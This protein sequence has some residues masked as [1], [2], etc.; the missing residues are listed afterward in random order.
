MYCRKCGNQLPEESFF[1]P[2]CGEKVAP[3][4]PETET[5]AAVAAEPVKMPETVSSAPQ[6]A[7]EAP[8]YTP[9]QAQGFTPYQAPG[10]TP[11]RAP[12][13]SAGKNGPL[14]SEAPLWPS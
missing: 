3:A 11:Y 5:P 1:C 14:S 6:P 12:E 4:E 7:P 8:A 13:K 9:Y 2:Y 10:F